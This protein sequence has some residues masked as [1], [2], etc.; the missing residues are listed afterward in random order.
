MN[1]GAVLTFSG[2]GADTLDYGD[3]SVV[4]NFEV[5]GGTVDF[6][7]TRQTVAGR[8]ITLSNGALLI[9]DGGSYSG[10]DY[11]AAMDFNIDVTINVTSGS[12]E[13]A[14]TSRLRNGDSRTVTWNVSEGAS[15]NVTGRIH[16]DSATATAGTIVKDGSGAATISSRAMLGKV[17]AKGGSMTIGYTGTDGNIIKNVEIHNGASFHIAQGASLSISSQNIGISGQDGTASMSTSADSETY[18]AGSSS[19]ELTQAH[20]TATG[21]GTTVLNNKLSNSSVENAGTGI[22]QVTHEQNQLSGVIASRGDVEIYNAGSGMTLDELHIA[23]GLNVSLLVGGVDTCAVASAIVVG[24]AE[25]EDGSSLNGNLTLAAGSTLEMQGTAQ[26]NGTLELVT[27]ADALTLAGSMYD[28]ICN[29]QRGDRIILFTGLESVELNIDGV[30]TSWEPGRR[31]LASEIFD[32]VPAPQNPKDQY[33]VT[34]TCAEVGGGE[35]AFF[36]APEPTTTTLS[37]LALTALAARRRRK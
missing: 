26:L 29:M 25:F 35:L 23:A 3:G 9:G 27:G 16:S 37:L 21:T 10:S 6:G 8:T 34:Y 36:L 11:T 19:I 4:R 15:L 18:S 31:V 7:S 30:C 22:L 5:N 33:Y 32:N 17:T 14:A 24:T 20:I 28:A 13:I 12:N 1:Q 2:T